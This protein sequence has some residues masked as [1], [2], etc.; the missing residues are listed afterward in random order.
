MFS[1]GAA[2]AEA[3]A[4]SAASAVGAVMPAARNAT[5][6]APATRRLGHRQKSAPI[7][8]RL[9]SIRFPDLFGCV[10]G[11]AQNASHAGDIRSRNPGTEL[12]FGQIL[13][14]RSA[15]NHLDRKPSE[16]GERSRFLNWAEVCEVREDAPVVRTAGRNV[17]QERGP[18]WKQKAMPAEWYSSLLRHG[19]PAAPPA[20]P[21]SLPSHRAS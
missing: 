12:D 8:D 6:K 18:Q 1:A 11:S 19:T 16:A 13:V 4:E 2:V 9:K 20:N 21:V 7:E 5:A 3:A 15:K 14:G 10:I 17:R